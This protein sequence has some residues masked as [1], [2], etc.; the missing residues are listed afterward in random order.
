MTRP[1][2]RN[3]G[4]R[5]ASAAPRGEDLDAQLVPAVTPDLD[6]E[7]EP[8]NL[9]EDDGFAI[10]AAPP[11]VVN[12]VPP[13]LETAATEPVT[14]V[15][16]IPQLHGQ[17]LARTPPSS[18]SRSTTQESIRTP[19]RTPRRSAGKRPRIS[20]P[21]PTRVAGP[22]R[23]TTADAVVARS[24]DVP[25][26]DSA[27]SDPSIDVAN[28]FALYQSYPPATQAVF[29][30]LQGH[31]L[32]ALSP[33]A[34]PT[35]IPSLISPSTTV[36]TSARLAAPSPHTATFPTLVPVPPGVHAAPSVPVPAMEPA[37]A[38]APMP[39]CTFL[40]TAVCMYLS[41]WLTIMFLRW[42]WCRVPRSCS[43]LRG[44]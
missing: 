26:T 18:P 4:G 21:T 6:L 40:C 39:S 35:A 37:A 36:P 41:L 16:P 42:S 25:G 22:S 43:C 5:A 30:R 24:I 27:Q 19:G 44:H 23:L 14:I 31:L 20:P 12:A 2:T 17:A 13:L 1:S 7:E 10:V 34:L 8:T 29:R 9:T 28:A 38:S 33:S 3:R 32:T 15:Q 11:D